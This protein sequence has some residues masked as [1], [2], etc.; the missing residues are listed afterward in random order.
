MNCIAYISGPMSGRKDHNF[1]A[2]YAAE[3]KLR[4][5]GMRP[6]NP[7]RNPAQPDWAAYMR[8]DLRQILECDTIVMLPGWEKSTGAKV[9]FLVANAIGLRVLMFDDL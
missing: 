1:P 2:F 6:I 4:S 8:Y 7:A 3:E 5:L 9:E